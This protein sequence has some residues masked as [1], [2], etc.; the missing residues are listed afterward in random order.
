MAHPRHNP[1]KFGQREQMT[2]LAEVEMD[3]QEDEDECWR[4]EEGYF[5]N[6]SGEDTPDSEWYTHELDFN[7]GW[8]W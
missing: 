8:G 3:R 6:D 5:F 7:D 4:G 2:A 1:P